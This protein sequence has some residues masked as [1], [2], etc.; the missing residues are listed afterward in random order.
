[1]NLCESAEESRFREEVTAFLA[2]SLPDAL[3]MRQD[4]AQLS[5]RDETLAWQRILHARGW[6]APHWPK[7][8]GGNGWTPRQRL[9]FEIE[10]AAAGAPWVNQQGINLLGPVV[11]AFGSAEQ[12][13]RLLAPLLRGDSYWVQGFS[14]P[15]A[16]SDLASL[17]TFAR[18]EGDRYY[19]TGQKIWTSHAMHADWVFLLVRTARGPRKQEGI[20]FMVTPLD[21]P[22][23]TIRPIRSID[24]LEHLTEIFLDEVE[25]P[26][27]N[28]IGEEG[29]G[30]AITK[31]ALGL[32][33]LFGACDIGGMKRDLGRLEAV[34]F[35]LQPGGGRAVDDPVAAARF[36]RLHMEAE[37]V[38]MS[39]LRAISTAPATDRIS[40]I[41][42]V[43]V[44]ELHQQIVE[45]L[46]EACD[47]RGPLF[48]P[49]P[50]GADARALVEGLDP[51]FA[52]V[53]AE[54]LYRR[55]SSIYGGTNEIQ[56]EILGRTLLK[57]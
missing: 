29:E 52:K 34:L 28:L 40:S 33:R 9:I 3:R 39:F 20:S 15:N 38:T 14:E 26:R 18:R 1:M 36:A 19:V 27:E 16:G 53:S 55:A 32:E 35:R 24:G 7:E 12:R 31:H 44:T 57:R 42:K 51:E 41:I 23:I 37:A 4:G 17:Q 6:G 13:E 54:V 49:D 25:I 5:T 22:G 48:H 11:C 47:A 56:R 50:W 43:K 30:W 10:C 2:A 46:F 8:H 45:A 21:A